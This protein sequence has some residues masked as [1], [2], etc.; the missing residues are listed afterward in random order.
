MHYSELTSTCTAAQ[1]KWQQRKMKSLCAQIQGP[2]IYIHTFYYVYY[3]YVQTRATDSGYDL[4]TPCACLYRYMHL[5][6]VR[7]CANI[8]VF[9]ASK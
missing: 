5:E 4:P 3:I 1:K 9:I 8:K 6:V 7:L 2:I